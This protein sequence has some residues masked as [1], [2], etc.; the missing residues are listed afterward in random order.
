MKILLVLLLLSTK[1]VA[2]QLVPYQVQVLNKWE[3]KPW[4]YK[5][6]NFNVVI[7]PINEAPNLF[8]NGFCVLVKNNKMGLID[9]KG[10][11]ILEPIYEKCS[12]LNGD[13]VELTDTAIKYKDAF[14][15]FYG[16]SQILESYFLNIK[17][18]QK[19][20]LND[21]SNGGIKCEMSGINGVFISRIYDNVLKRSFY[22]LKNFNNEI[23]LPNIYKEINKMDDTHL[24]VQTKDDLYGFVNAKTWVQIP[25]YNYLYGFDDGV[26]LVKQ[27][28]KCGY[29]N[30]EGKQTIPLQYDNAYRFK[31]GFADVSIN[32]KF[33]V[34]NKAGQA[35]IES[36]K[37]RYMQDAINNVFI[38]K[39]LND[40]IYILNKD[41]KNLAVGA[42]D[43]VTADGKSFLLLVGK[44][45]YSLVDN[46]ISQLPIDNAV[47]IGKTKMG[48]Y[49]VSSKA[50]NEKNETVSVFNIKA[51]TVIANQEKFFKYRENEDL[52][53]LEAYWEVKKPITNWEDDVIHNVY[54]YISLSGKTYSDITK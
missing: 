34:I 43:I 47:S 41:G 16:N 29:I 27:N 49:M 44:L 19:A 35:I 26:A 20:F 13:I 6:I 3:D 15:S 54:S 7:Q 25:I 17:T 32:H 45:V 14:S 46:S 42:N 31:N 10:N 40:S 37:I 51:T 2:Q 52:Q 9:A 22:G 4:G 38:V 12:N 33:F 5:D 39:H 28:N 21:K 8:K 24:S 18:K 11:I 50:D 48:F 36:D 30:S 53:L 23:L 1:C